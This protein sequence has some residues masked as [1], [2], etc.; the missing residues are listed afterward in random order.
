MSLIKGRIADRRVLPLT[1]RS[2]KA[3]VLTGDGCEAPVEGTPPGGP[4][5]P[6]VAHLLLACFDKELE[7][8]GQRCVRSADESNLYGKSPRVGPRVRTRG[9]RCVERRVK[10]T[11][12]AA[13]SAGDRP[14]R[15]TLLGFT[16]TRRRPH[17]CQG[18]AKALQALQQAVRQRPGRTRGVSLQRVGDGLRQDRDGWYAYL[19]FREGQSSVQEPDSGV[20]R[21]RRG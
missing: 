8:R 13:T 5:S 19:R 3:G 2:L 10:R 4:R 21:R 11:V 16:V 1:R 20:R 6:L 14:W 15:R 17:R 18:S 7:R 12:N 9:T